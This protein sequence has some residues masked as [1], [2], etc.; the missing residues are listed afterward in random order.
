M[1]KTQRIISF[2]AKRGEQ[3]DSYINNKILSKTDNLFANSKSQ[4]EKELF[5]KMPIN[6]KLYPF[7]VYTLNEDLITP[8]ISGRWKLKEHIQFLEGLDKY[9]TDWKKICPLIKTRTANQIRSHAQKFYLKLKHAKDKQL[10][11]DFTSNDIKNIRD[12]IN[13]IKSINSD[14]DIIKVF[15]FLSEKCSIDKKEKKKNILKKKFIIK[16]AK[17]SNFDKNNNN[18]NNFQNNIKNSD[19]DRF[20][21]GDNQEMNDYPKLIEN[22]FVNNNIFN[23]ISTSNI[24]FM[25]HI[26]IPNYLNNMIF[27]NNHNIIGNINIFNN[28]SNNIMVQN[29]LENKLSPYNNLIVNNSV[30]DFNFVE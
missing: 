30:K 18:I 15:L 21:N 8:A 2:K 24:Y 1:F 17:K 7:K 28:F 16:A 19:S 13:H 27:I 26:F 29:E 22:R 9:G 14:Y 6:Q 4:N 10:D 5:Q 3:N 23:N 12:M 20:S 25:N 11:I